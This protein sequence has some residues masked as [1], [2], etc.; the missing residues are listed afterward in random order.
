MDPLD[1]SLK[2]DEAE[3]KGGSERFEGDGDGGSSRPIGSEGVRME[4]EIGRLGYRWC[5]PPPPPAP[6]VVRRRGLYLG[7]SR[8]GTVNTSVSEPHH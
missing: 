2:L 6:A 3:L 5:A 7:G 1:V 8:N 4:C